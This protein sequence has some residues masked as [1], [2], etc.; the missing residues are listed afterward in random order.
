AEKG[1]GL[2]KMKAK[3]APATGKRVAIVGSG[4][5]GLTAAYYLAKQGHAVTV[6]EVLPEPGGMMR[7]GIP[8]YRLPREVLAEEIEEIR[9]A[10]VDI[11]T[12]TKVNSLD[13]LFENG[14]NAIFLA[15][16][17]HQG[18]KLGIEGEDNP[19]VMEGVSFLREISMGNKVRVGN[20]VAVIGGGN[21]ATDASRCALRLGASEVTIIYRRTRAE[22]PASREEIEEALHEGV[23]IAFLTAPTR[24]ERK[25]GIVVLTCTRMELGAVDA[26]GR[27]RPVPIKGSEFSPDFDAVITAI[28]Q[29]PEA[30]EQFGLPLGKGNT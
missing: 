27:R 9:S 20:R 13:E 17:A 24:I 12:N 16:G 3:M 29:M 4:P 14:Y 1:N 28:G 15:I 23:R 19:E 8:E 25:D 21:V 30:P 26:G 6:F 2:W 11:R 10:G 7:Y 22:M 18:A 5:A